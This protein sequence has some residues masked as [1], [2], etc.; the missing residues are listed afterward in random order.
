MAVLCRLSGKNLFFTPC[1]FLMVYRYKD[2][3]TIIGSIV[4]KFDPK[5][6]LA[7][8]TYCERNKKYTGKAEF[9]FSQDGDQIS[10]IGYYTEGKST[11]WKKD[12]SGDKSNKPIPKQLDRFE[13]KKGLCFSNK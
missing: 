3:K 10:F 4:G 11:S 12:W 6:G 5:T 1:H 7:K 8:G 9:A 13:N 2:G